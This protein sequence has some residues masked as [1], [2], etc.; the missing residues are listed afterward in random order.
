MTLDEIKH[1]LESIQQVADT[2]DESA[3]AAE[4]DLAW[5]FILWAADCSDCEVTAAKAHEVLKSRDIKFE[6]WC[7]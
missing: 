7:A 1:R 2:D 4:D 6:R 5:D 3:H